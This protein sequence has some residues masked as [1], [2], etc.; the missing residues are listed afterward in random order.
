MF[1]IECAPIGLSVSRHLRR[2]CTPLALPGCALL[3]VLTAGTLAQVFSFFGGVEYFSNYVVLGLLAIDTALTERASFERAVQ[4]WGAT[5][6]QALWVL[7][8][9]SAI[10]SI[11][12]LTN[13]FCADT[14]EYHL[15][16]FRWMAGFG[17]VPGLANLQSEFRIA[18]QTFEFGAAIER[19][20]GSGPFQN[21]RVTR[22]PPRPAQA[23][24]RSVAISIVLYKR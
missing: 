2:W 24:D 11:N 15:S 14:V 4:A 5:N 20:V 23:C 19:S 10:F 8:P 16:E 6:R 13:A 7:I 17:T 22:K 9:L 12:A 1:Y 21:H 18:L 3:G